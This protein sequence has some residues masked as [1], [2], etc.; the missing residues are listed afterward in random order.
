MMVGLS[1]MAGTIPIP[2]VPDRVLYQLRGAVAYEVAS[3]NG[4]SLSSDA[5]HAL[6]VVHTTSFTRK[7]L[8]KGAELTAGAF[9]KRMGPL[10]RFRGAAGALEVYALGYLLDRYM[11]EVRPIGP[12]RMQQ[13]EALRIRKA[14]DQATRLA[15]KPD[16]KPTPLLLGEGAEDLRDG[17]T[18]WIDSLLVGATTLPSYLERRLDAAFGEV[19][20]ASPSL[21]DGD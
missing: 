7:M 1:L 17:F 18:R 6:A 20:I 3:R 15:C 4:L 10:S 5:R 14:I 19:L 13:A 11:R 16:T 9:L 2:F 21:R 12:L 8:R